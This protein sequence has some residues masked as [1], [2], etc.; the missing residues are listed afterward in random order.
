MEITLRCGDAA[1]LAQAAAQF[2]ARLEAVSYKKTGS[3]DGGSISYDTS[4][5]ISAGE[6]VMTELLCFPA[7]DI[8]GNIYYDIPERDRSW[9]GVTRYQSV[10][11]P[12]GT[13]RLKSSSETHWS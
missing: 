7:L 1:V 10:T 6:A 5:S 9:W 4:L 8:S 11:D 13:R 2:E 3:V 12:D